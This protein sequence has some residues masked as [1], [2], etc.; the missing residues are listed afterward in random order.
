MELENL[1]KSELIALTLEKGLPVTRRE[2]LRK[3]SHNVRFRENII[4][5]LKAMMFFNQETGKI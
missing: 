3:M 2:I 5:I 4:V 1:T